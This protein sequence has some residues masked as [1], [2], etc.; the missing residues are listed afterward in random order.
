MASVKV[1]L[2]RAYKKNGLI[3]FP[4]LF[5]SLDETII[6]DCSSTD[7]IIKTGINM[8]KQYAETHPGVSFMP[9]YVILSG[10]R[11]YG[12]RLAASNENPEL[13]VWLK[14]ED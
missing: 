1:S 9:R 8:A 4:D 3:E 2:V 13:T 7:A 6:T 5:A 10:R 11:P 14:S 12:F